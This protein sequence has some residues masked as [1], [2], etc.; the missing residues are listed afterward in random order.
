MPRDPINLSHQERLSIVNHLQIFKSRS[1]H[2]VYTLVRE[3]ERP[4]GEV[5]HSD[6]Q[7]SATFSD[8]FPP[9]ECQC[10]EVIDSSHPKSRSV[11]SP[12]HPSASVR[13]LC[14]GEC[15]TCQSASEGSQCPTS[16]V[17]V[18][19]ECS[20]TICETCSDHEECCECSLG[21][22]G[23]DCGVCIDC[24]TP[25]RISQNDSYFAGPYSE[26]FGDQATEMFGLGNCLPHLPMETASVEPSSFDVSSN[27]TNIPAPTGLVPPRHSFHSDDDYGHEPTSIPVSSLEARTATDRT[28][29]TCTSI[30][31]DSLSSEQIAGHTSRVSPLLNPVSHRHSTDPA[32]EN[33]GPMVSIDN[34]GVHGSDT[35]QESPADKKTVPPSARCQWVDRHGQSCRRSFVVGDDLHEH[36]QTA[37]GVKSEVFCRW[38]GCR[39]GIFGASPHRYANSV[40]RHIWGHSGYRPY[41]CPT[42]FEGF[43]AAKVLEEHFTNFH[44]GRKAFACDICTHQCTSAANLKRHTDEKHRAERFQCEFCNRNGRVKLF[45]RGSNLARHFRKC[46]HVLAS[47][48]NAN[49]AAAGKID[50]EWFPPGYRGGNHGMDRAKIIPPNYLTAPNG[51]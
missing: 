37:H 27:D 14:G 28:A 2:V 8:C 32:R 48:P 41:K 10:C 17:C 26:L 40:Q 33:G 5:D 38:L 51:T 13:G 30:S 42:C 35:G 25:D 20:E 44:L 23:L 15:Q 39:V 11:N 3:E 45:P 36:L 50:D 22:C 29:S 4:C 19:P 16:P 9:A 12:T 6:Q 43:A 47:F 21:D 46:K 34:A 31:R 1:Q 18:D 7:T 49:G 24:G